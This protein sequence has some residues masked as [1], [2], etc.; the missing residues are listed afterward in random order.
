MRATLTI[1]ATLTVE[2]KGTIEL[3]LFAEAAPKTV[4]NFVE[5]AKR[6][7][8]DDLTFH[9][10]VDDFMVQAGCPAGTGQGGPGYHIADE[11]NDNLHLTGSLAMANTGEP[12]SGGSQ[13]YLC[14]RP[15]PQLDGKHTVFGRVA[16]GVDVLYKIEQGDV[17]EALTVDAD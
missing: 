3:D 12:N 1:R 4:A 10:L 15:L 14:H 8:Y 17:I 16:V 11:F 9:R 7:F 13:F 6:G 5:L 2:D